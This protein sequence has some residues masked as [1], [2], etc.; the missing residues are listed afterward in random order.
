[1]KRISI[2]L[3]AGIAIV[4]GAWAQEQPWDDDPGVQAVLAQRRVGIEAMVAGTMSAD[5]QLLS[6]T[7][8][9]NTPDS[10]VVPGSVLLELF[11]Q[12]TLRY[13]LVEQT[14]DYARSHGPDMV[15]L[16]GEEMVVPGD[17]L[18]NAGKRIFRR[19]TDVFRREDGE[20]RHDL[21]HA[22]VLRIED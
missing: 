16:M 11:N 7:F 1:M 8:V 19:F 10:S 20:W 2:G 22:H 3:I 4:S 13:D 15:V 6:T 9:A 12:G 14:V 21:R 17:G 18:A 5:N